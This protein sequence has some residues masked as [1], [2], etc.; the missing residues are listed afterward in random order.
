M[1]EE[2]ARP[3]PPP[4]YKVALVTWLGVYP[5]LTLILAVLGP[6]MEP[7]PLPIRTLLVSLV[8]VAALSWLILPLL[9]RLLQGW[10]SRS[11]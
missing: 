1:T 4:R 2:Q 9:T 6:T 8:M 7:W 3:T 5:T 11:N 10:M